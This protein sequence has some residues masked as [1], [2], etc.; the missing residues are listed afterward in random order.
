[1]GVFEDVVSKAKIAADYAGKKTGE[2]VEISKLRLAA[3]ELQDKINKSF[4]ELG[5]VVYEAGKDGSDRSDVLKEKSAAI[6]SLYEQLNETNE[7]IAALRRMKKCPA[8]NYDNPE[9]ANYCL[10][11]GAK[12]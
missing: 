1:M 9:D 12:L 7:K 8:C 10:K 3:T 2:I 5:Y 6:D 4:Q 11:C